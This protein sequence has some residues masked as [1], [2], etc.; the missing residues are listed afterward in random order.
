[1]SN[2]HANIFEIIRKIQKVKKLAIAAEVETLTNEDLYRKYFLN[3][4]RSDDTMTRGLRLTHEGFTVIKEFFDHYEIPIQE[5]FHITS[6]HILFLDRSCTLPFYISSK[7]FILFE[8]EL[9]MRAK[10]I[11]DF[12]VL[13]EAFEDKKII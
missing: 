13:I 12:D 8:R 5:K 10:L 7:Q 4:R 2:I 9:A 11:G 1:M 3:F 6:K